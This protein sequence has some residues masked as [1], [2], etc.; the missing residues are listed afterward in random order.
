MQQID[1]ATARQWIERGEATLVDV[2]EAGEYAA[3]HVPGA[4]HVPLG[5]LETAA[6][7]AGKLVLMC[8]SGMR[9]TRGCATLAPK[10]HE[11]FSLKGGIA[12]WASADGRIEPA[13]GTADSASLTAR[14]R[15]G[16]ALVLG[17]GLAALVHPGF[18]I[19]AAFAGARLF[20]LM[21]PTPQGGGCASK[22]AG[23]T[24]CSS[25]DSKTNGG[26]CSGCGAK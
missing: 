12:A 13:P 3:L 26:G 10:G 1:A 19:L 24:S 11:S 21:L 18:L 14:V 6:L 7:P 8:A 25:P 4:L 17:L 2:R 9:S 15:A 23:K 16:G 22:S 20:T 5:Q